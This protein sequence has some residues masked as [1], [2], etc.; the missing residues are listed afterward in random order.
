MSVIA[1]CQTGRYVKLDPE[2][3]ARIYQA[4]DSQ[5]NAIVWRVTAPDLE[6]R[7]SV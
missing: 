3:L 2:N 4:G 1:Y 7:V 5:L 6:I